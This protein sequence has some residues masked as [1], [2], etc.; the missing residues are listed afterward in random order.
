MATEPASDSASQSALR[1]AAAAARAALDDEPAVQ[2][3]LVDD[4]EA[5]DAP[6]HLRERKA[7][8]RSR[9]GRRKKPEVADHEH[10]YEEKSAVGGIIRRVCSQ[11]GHVSFGSEDVYEDWGA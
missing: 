6:R 8:R 3:D 1:S 5:D 9:R 10:T 4:T 2:A 7:G 11:C